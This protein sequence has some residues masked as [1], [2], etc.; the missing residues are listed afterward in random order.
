MFMSQPHSYAMRSRRSTE[1]KHGDGCSLTI[2]LESIV[3]SSSGVRGGAA[4][5]AFY[6]YFRSEKSHLEHPFLYIWAMAGP[7]KRRGARENFPPFLPS[8]RACTVHNVQSV[9]QPN[10][11]WKNI[12][13]S[14]ELLKNTIRSRK[15]MHTFSE[16]HAN[17]TA[18]IPTLHQRKL[19]KSLCLSSVTN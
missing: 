6:A 15:F 7:P 2:W 5:N 4:K 19:S 18:P 12:D 11:E 10:T 1:K 9:D 13:I 16:L 17:F 14:R 8:R 3:S